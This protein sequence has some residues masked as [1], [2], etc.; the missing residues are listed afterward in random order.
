MD[1][2]EKQV[3]KIMEPDKDERKKLQAAIEADP[4]RRDAVRQIAERIRSN[5]KWRQ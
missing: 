3:L 1:K 2:F 4:K 5:K